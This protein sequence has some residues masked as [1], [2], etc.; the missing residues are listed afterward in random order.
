MHA[1]RPT[2]G[3]VGVPLAVPCPIPFFECQAAFLAEHWAR[4]E[5]NDGPG[6]LSSADE[7]ERWV[8]AGGWWWGLAAIG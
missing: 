2:L 3:F 6:A 5:G 4:P 1:R 7:R 8:C